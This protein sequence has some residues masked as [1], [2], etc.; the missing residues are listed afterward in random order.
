[1]TTSIVIPT[2]HPSSGEDSK[3]ISSSSTNRKRRRR[4]R[5]RMISSSTAR[6]SSSST[7]RKEISIDKKPQ[8]SKRSFSTDHRCQRNK[9]SRD[10]SFISPPSTQKQLTRRPHRRDVSLQHSLPLSGRFR[11]NHASPL[12]V[13]LT[14]TKPT[15]D[16]LDNSHQRQQRRSR[17]ESVDH[18][19]STLLNR[20]HQQFYRPSSSRNNNNNNNNNIPTHQ[21]PSYPVY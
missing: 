3:N 21:I 13:L 17:L 1:M 15:S 20:I 14:S 10:N 11:E 18:K 4:I 19:P 7:E 8:V 5:K 6:S 16:F 9:N 12:S 2:I